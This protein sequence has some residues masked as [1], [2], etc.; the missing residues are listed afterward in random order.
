MREQV[1]IRKAEEASALGEVSVRDVRPSMRD[2][3]FAVMSRKAY[4]VPIAG[5]VRR[6]PPTGIWRRELDLQALARA[7]EGAGASALAVGTDGP[8]FGGTIEDLHALGRELLVPVLRL[9]YVL[10]PRQL[11]ASRLAGADAVLISAGMLEVPQLTALVQAAQAMHMHVVLE[12]RDEADL[13]RAREVPSA[14]L[15]FGDLTGETRPWDPSRVLG[16]V[17]QAP[18][19]ATLIALCGVRDKADL[20]ALHGKVDAALVSSA[21]LEAEDPAAAAASWFGE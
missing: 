3:H 16:L 12:A 1:K 5:V 4:V 11:Y 20:E 13:A 2:F 10:D 8:L 21:W 7:A 17:A 19:R 6:D 18:Q 14:I 15:G 9:D